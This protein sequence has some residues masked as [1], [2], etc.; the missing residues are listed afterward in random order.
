LDR[1]WAEDGIIVW[2]HM[3]GEWN[4]KMTIF[5]KFNIRLL[6]F[7][8][9]LCLILIGC[10]SKLT[11]LPQQSYDL[12]PAANAP[13][14][15]KKTVP[16]L[17]SPLVEE[18]EQ[19]EDN[20]LSQLEKSGTDALQME[21]VLPSERDPGVLLTHKKQKNTLIT[22]TP[23]DV[24][25]AEFAFDNADLHE[26]LD[27]VL[28]ENF[29][30]DYMVD[31]S[32]RKKVSFHIS[33]EFTKKDIINKL[34]SVLQMS[35]LAVVQGPGGIV[36]I[37]DRRDAV[38]ASDYFNNI[39]EHSAGDVTRMIRLKYIDVRDAYKRIKAILSKNAV[40]ISDA[41][42]NSLIITDLPENIN[43]IATL[44]GL[45]DVP[46]F[47]DISWKICPVQRGDAKDIAKDI[48]N[49]LTTKG[50]YKRSGMSDGGYHLIPL[51]TINGILV[52]TKWP[53]VIPMVENWIAILDQG[54]NSSTDVF[55]YFVENSSAV[56]L[57]DILKQ[58]YGEKKN[59]EK[60]QKI[61]DPVSNKNVS[62]KQ[63]SSFSGE[64]SGDVEII[65]DE[66]TNAI[67]F[68]AARKDYVIIKK[69]LEKLDIV[70]RQVLLNVIV[71]EVTLENSTQYGVQWFLKNNAS[72]Y[73]GTSVLDI[74]DSL[75]T[76]STSLGASSGFSYSIFNSSDVLR[77]LV[78]AIGKDSK[79]NIL[80]TPNVLAVDNKKAEIEVGEDVPTVTGTVTDANGG[81]TNTVQYKKTGI[82]LGVT[83]SINSSG[84]VKLD[85]TQEVSEKGTLDEE[86]GNYSILTRKVTTSLVVQDNQT[87]FIGGMMR[88]NRSV[89]D[90]GIP[91]LKDIPILG[92]FF[93]NGTN[94]MAKTELI[95]LITPHVVKN[96][97]DADQMTD[98]FSKNIKSITRLLEEQKQK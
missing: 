85:L 19:A 30:I 67:V 51:T 57:A 53:Q 32:I 86:L 35:G 48:D 64:L 33:G 13:P 55:V 34:N 39:T 15:I 20:S 21:Y 10:S 81:V 12:Q 2:D 82:L 52:L 70:A 83:P 74:N 46:F 95:F 16:S 75:R 91:F 8:I 92:Y 1:P 4:Y 9:F 49:I 90:S 47:K 89:S 45:M 98:M 77:S 17:P 71:A 58:V 24:V 94:D 72:D 38:S 61:V 40:V 62:E 6:I 18:Y 59:K 43:N 27:I 69:V 7:G 14:E 42:T 65:P 84:L 68:K 22:S 96:R 63:T 93:K 37:I 54:D 73:S 50:F 3:F 25:T 26:V 11:T 23:D 66:I 80:S 97:E 28:F 88:Y 41:T 31:P 60:Q 36:K 56:A 79:V 76:A 78:T 29:K 44:L 87:I 5:K